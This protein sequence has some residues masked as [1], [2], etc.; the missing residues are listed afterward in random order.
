MQNE[1][2]QNVMAIIQH[3]DIAGAV[4][5][6]ADAQMDAIATQVETLAARSR[7]FAKDIQSAQ[8]DLKN[9]MANFNITFGG[10]SG[11]DCWQ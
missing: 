6:R 4:R 9:V 8:D 5:Q 11:A 10:L 2:G 3:T 1:I 7:G